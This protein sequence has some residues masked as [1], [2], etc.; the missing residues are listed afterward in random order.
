MKKSGE[1]VLFYFTVQKPVSVSPN[2]TEHRNK[3]Y[4]K[5]RSCG[6]KKYKFS[7]SGNSANRNINQETTK[8]VNSSEGNS[9]MMVNWRQSSFNNILKNQKTKIY[10]Y[11][12]AHH[13][14]KITH[15]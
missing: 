4:Q 13:N 11:H 15:K 10:Y 12:H 9:S 2:K 14:H 7:V 3:H 1:F 8:A 6:T 5:N